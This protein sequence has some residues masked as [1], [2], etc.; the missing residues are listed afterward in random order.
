LIRDHRHRQFA[1]RVAAAVH[2]RDEGFG[3]LRIERRHLEDVRATD[4]G[5]RSRAGQH[6]GAQVIAFCQRFDL[7]DESD[8]QMAL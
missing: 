2:Q 4:E 1:Q 6:D 7:A 5:L 3:V 8:H